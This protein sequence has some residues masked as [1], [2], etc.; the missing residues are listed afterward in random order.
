MR[1]T[2][3]C[4]QN[5]TLFRLSMFCF[6]PLDW[7]SSYWQFLLYC[8]VLFIHYYALLSCH[9]PLRF[10][11]QQVLTITEFLFLLFRVYPLVCSLCVI[12]PAVCRSSMYRIATGTRPLFFKELEALYG[13]CSANRAA[14]KPLI[15]AD[16]RI[17]DPHKLWMF[18]RANRL[19]VA[20]SRGLNCR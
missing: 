14:T 3:L 6:V 16:Y 2:R 12:Q 13:Y 9:N 4:G 17:L 18:C 11:W 5:A 8:A 1:I 20:R 15:Y 19:A 7:F 10:C